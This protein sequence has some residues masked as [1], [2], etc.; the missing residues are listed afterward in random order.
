MYE[1]DFVRIEEIDLVAPELATARIQAACGERLEDVVALPLRQ[2]HGT[3]AIAGLPL[4]A[5]LPQVR[6]ESD[7]D[8]YYLEL[9]TLG[10]FFEGSRVRVA[11]A[12]H[13]QKRNE[14]EQQGVFR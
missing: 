6:G 3:D 8:R 11:T 1:I 5:L 2:E 7:D 13:E 10:R 4:L 9:V 14:D 12:L